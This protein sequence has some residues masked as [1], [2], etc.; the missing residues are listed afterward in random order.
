MCGA[1]GTTAEV[2]R[3][4]AVRVTPL[5]DVD[6]TEMVRGLRTYPLLSGFRGAPPADVASLEE[7]ILRV[8]AMVD[9]HH[10]IVEMDCNPVFVRTEGSVVADVRIRIAGDA[11]STSS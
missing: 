10:E 3:D 8:A 5:T 1:G 4:V 9:A 2:L 7:L 11:A 6:A